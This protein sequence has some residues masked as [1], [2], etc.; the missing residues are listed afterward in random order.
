MEETPDEVFAA[1]PKRH[2]WWFT[3]ACQIPMIN[4]IQ[5]LCRGRTTLLLPVLVAGL[6]D[7]RA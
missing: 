3:E 7:M 1:L 2:T 6:N 4:P 5:I